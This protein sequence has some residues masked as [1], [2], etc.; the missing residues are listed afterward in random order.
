[1]AI[2]SEGSRVAHQDRPADCGTIIRIM[3]DG[4][5]GAQY[6]VQWDNHP[7]GPIAEVALVLCDSN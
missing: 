1:M 6:F 4:I 5:A 3:S 2:F 7:A